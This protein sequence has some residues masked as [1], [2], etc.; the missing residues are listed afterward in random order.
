MVVSSDTLE[1]LKAFEGETPCLVLDLDKVDDNLSRLQACMPHA[2]H[3]YAIKANPNSDVLKTLCRN[4]SYFE[5]ASVNEI[6]MCLDAGVKPDRILYGNP[7][8]KSRQIRTA[9]DMGIT[10]FVFDNIIELEKI[11]A[12]APG[13]KVICRIIADGHGAVSPLTIKFGCPAE[14][15]LQWLG[16]ATEMGVIPFGISFHTGS[17]QLE[18]SAWEAPIREA[19]AI[20]K[21]LEKR[22]IELQILDVGGGF[23][24]SYR[25]PVLPIEAYGSAIIDYVS[26]YFDRPPIV[27]TEPGRYM[28]GDAGHIVSEVVLVSP[29]YS[30][31]G[32]KWVYLDIGRYGGL[33]EEKID[34]PVVSFRDAQQGKVILAGQTCDSNDVIYREDFGYTLPIDLEPGERVIL[35]N[36]GAYTTTYSTTLNGF[37]LLKAVTMRSSEIN[38]TD[39]S[40][41]LSL[42]PQDFIEAYTT[43]KPGCSNLIS[44]DSVEKRETEEFGV[45]IYALK[46]FKEGEMI[47]GFIGEL[48]MALLQHS[49]QVRTGLNIH[50]PYFVGYFLHHCDPNCRLD[51]ENQLVYCIRDIQVG[52]PLTMDYAS[53]EEALFRQFACMCDAP[54]CRLWVTGYAEE[55]NEEGQRYLEGYNKAA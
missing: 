10:Q 21:E 6:Q 19:A 18:P 33:V 36:T 48:T 11:A 35:A 38:K 16:Q 41:N 17:Q 49:L 3:Y 51:M 29:S 22:G 40:G 23:P 46:P 30:D 50:D 31:P 34:Y 52:E 32:L 15:A 26:Q 8:K 2:Q 1:Y 14:L 45:G 54:D 43:D 44:K 28:T 39:S 27:Y 53:T 25:D 13:A 12:A 24:V 20:F 47:G 42:Y 7:L 55:V 9:W 37:E 4:G 5:V